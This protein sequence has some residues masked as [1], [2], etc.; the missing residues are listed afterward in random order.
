MV[1][2]LSTGH[3]RA[4]CASYDCHSSLPEVTTPGHPARPARRGGRGERRQD[5][6]EPA[7]RRRLDDDVELSRARSPVAARRWRLRA[8]GLEPGDRLLTWSPSTPELPGRLLRRDAGRPRPRPARPAHVARGGRGHRPRVGRPAPRSSGPGATRP[9]R[10]RPGS[11]TS[12]RR[13]STRSR[14]T[15]SRTTPPSRPTGRPS[16]AAWAPPGPDRRLRARLHLRHDRHAE[17]RDARPRQRASPRSRRSTGSSRR[18]STGSSRC[19]RCRTCS[20]RRSAVLRACRSGRTSCTSAAATR[21]SSSMRC[22]TTGSPRW[23]SC[24]QVLDL[25]WSAIEREV[26]KRGRTTA[27][28][29][30]RSDRPPPADARAGG[31]LFGSVHAQLGGSFRLFLSAGA[32]LPPALQQAWED[33]GVT[34]LQGYGATETGT[35]TCTTPRGPRPRDGRAAARRGRDAARRRRRG[36]VPRPDRCSRATGSTRRPTA[37]AFTED[38]WYRTGDIGHLDAAGR[39]ILSGRTKDIIVLPNGFN[40]YPEDIENALRIAG[41]RDSVVL[42]T[43]PGRIEAVVLGSAAGAPACRGRRRTRRRRS[44]ASGSMRPS[45]RPTRRSGRTSASPAGGS[46]PRRTSRGPT[47]SRSSATRSASDGRLPVEAPLAGRR[48]VRPS[49]ESPAPQVATG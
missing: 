30:L 18:W 1:Q 40:V 41:I 4:I 49:T 46:G 19:C 33:L 27:F 11:S 22:A 5:R 31:V 3:D 37:A 8:L 36:P 24:P 35:G 26:E 17:G 42:E 10:A 25:F 34:V 14:P 21:G 7:A 12:R 38:G 29:R 48:G 28:D 44:C 39:L 43:Q 23:S 6:A 47:R 13:P 20:S 45:R 9:T 15:A 2:D 32:F 16:S